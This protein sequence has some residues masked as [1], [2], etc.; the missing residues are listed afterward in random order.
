ML[1]ISQMDQEIEYQLACDEGFSAEEFMEADIDRRQS[2][3]EAEQAFIAE[4]MAMRV[5]QMISTLSPFVQEM[6]QSDSRDADQA[7]LTSLSSTVEHLKASREEASRN[8]RATLKNLQGKKIHC[9]S[10]KE[11]LI[12]HQKLKKMPKTSQLGTFLNQGKE[13]FCAYLARRPI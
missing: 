11:K 6:Q 12:S 7:Y 4:Q 8:L 10:L 13:K 5:Q 3:L 2:A 1:P 9:K